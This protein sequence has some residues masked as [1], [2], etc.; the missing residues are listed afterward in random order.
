M[1]W[2]HRKRQSGAYLALV[3]LAL[4]IVLSFGHV[5]LSTVRDVSLSAATHQ[6]TPTQAQSQPPAQNPGGDD[7]YCAICVSMF[8]VSTS[9]TPA[10]PVLP[11]PA[12]FQRIGHS[13]DNAG[14]LAEP[15]HPAFQSRAPPAA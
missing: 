5:H 15:R 10:P 13:F 4:Q 3:V 14:D 9:Y 1:E 2:I 6:I 12:V 7:D 11:V 8:L